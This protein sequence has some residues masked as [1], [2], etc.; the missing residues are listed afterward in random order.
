MKIV[1]VLV[2]GGIVLAVEE[3]REALLVRLNNYN[4]GDP[5]FLPFIH[6]GPTGDVKM[7]VRRSE[8]IAVRSEHEYDELA[9]RKIAK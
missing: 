3:S 9:P 6:A 4:E 2:R 1:E 5:L 7:W 8:I